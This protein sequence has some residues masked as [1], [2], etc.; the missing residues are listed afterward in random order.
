MSASVA[1]SPEPGGHCRA[2]HDDTAGVRG[3]HALCLRQGAVLLPGLGYET[4]QRMSRVLLIFKIILL[5]FHL[6]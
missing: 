1:G 3:T 2:D 5:L 6:I 4:K